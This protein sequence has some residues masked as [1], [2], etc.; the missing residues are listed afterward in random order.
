MQ[1]SQE[2]KSYKVST[3]LSTSGLHAILINE[4]QLFYPRT[5]NP[6][7]QTVYC[8]IQQIQTRTSGLFNITPF[9]SRPGLHVVA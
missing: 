6:T 1:K 3:N 7:C 2:F 4:K 9:N 5:I 8:A